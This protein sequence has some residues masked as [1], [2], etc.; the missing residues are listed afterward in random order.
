MAKQGD[1]FTKE[2]Y[3]LRM[4]RE[5]SFVYG[6]LASIRM[7]KARDSVLM[8][9]MYLELFSDVFA[10]VRVSYAKKARQLA[11]KRRIG[12]R[13]QVTFLAHNGKAVAVFVS[14][15]AR[16]YGDLIVRTF[17]EFLADVRE[18]GS[19]AVV[20]GRV[21]KAMFR[22]LEPDRPMAYFDLPD[23]GL[24]EE[25]MEA[26]MTHLVSY[27]EIRLYHGKY[28]SVLSQKPAMFP[29]S[30][31]VEVSDEE[32]AKP[33]RYLFE[34]EIEKILQFF[35]RGIFGNLFLQTIRETQLARSASRLVAMD[36][37]RISI[38]ERR[39]AMQIQE[40]REEHRQA[41]REQLNSL[42]PVM[43]VFGGG[44]Y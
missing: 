8:S 18:R 35:E 11:T 5:I 29:L 4:L 31:R 44:R 34:P 2:L 27:E 32:V 1:L 19:E 12:K 33:M 6:Q 22:S 15:N 3:E 21:G 37:A 16:L 42:G 23:E 9:R 43:Q 26:I 30:A 38:E 13:E 41:N 20:I 25:A 28:A 36:R 24:D 40:L 17:R 7:A 39:R 10:E 14:A